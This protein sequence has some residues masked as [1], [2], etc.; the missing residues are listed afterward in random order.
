MISISK[1]SIQVATI[2]PAKQICPQIN[3]LPGTHPTILNYIQK[4][5]I[6]C[7][8]IKIIKSKKLNYKNFNSLSLLYLDPPIFL[9]DG[10]DQLSL[11]DAG[12]A[13]DKFL[14]AHGVLEIIWEPYATSD[15]KWW[16]LAPR[17][18]GMPGD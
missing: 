4:Y 9:I 5:L 1:D 10:S 18:K 7:Q 12:T 11:Y 13:V 17:Q 8:N 6:K 3:Q 14:A 16:I 2:I 15:P